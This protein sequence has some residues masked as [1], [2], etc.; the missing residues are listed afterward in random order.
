MEAQSRRGWLRLPRSADGRD[1]DEQ[2]VIELSNACLS[3]QG[4]A[5]RSCDDA[6]VRR[7][8]RFLPTLGGP[9]RPSIVDLRCNGCGDCLDVC[10]ANA[11]RLKP[12]PPTQPDS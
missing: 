1:A 11:L 8:F 4:I 2:A 9:A 12:R 10:P 3:V 6:C 5:C 7:V